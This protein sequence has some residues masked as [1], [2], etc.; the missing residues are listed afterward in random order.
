MVVDALADGA[1]RVLCFLYRQWGQFSAGL[2]ADAAGPLD[3]V[4]VS[5]VVDGL[6]DGVWGVL[7]PLQAMG[8][9]PAGKITD[10]AGPLDPVLV[11]MVVDA[12]ADGFVP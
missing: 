8:A 2:S 3:S 9:I 12:L 1:W 4:F 6:A 7:F 10:A 5:M 11:S